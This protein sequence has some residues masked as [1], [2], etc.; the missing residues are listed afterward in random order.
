MNL[1]ALPIQHK[2]MKFS[3]LIAAFVGL[4]LGLSALMP[5]VVEFVP[6][7][8][9]RSVSCVFFIVWQG[10]LEIPFLA[11]VSLIEGCKKQFGQAA[12][13]CVLLILDTILVPLT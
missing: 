3:F 12:H 8:A 2:K 13:S 10:T 5:V 1:L 9:A 7:V 6:V 4:V 11:I